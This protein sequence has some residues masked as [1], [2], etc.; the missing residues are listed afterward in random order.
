MM[1]TQNPE[2]NIASAKVLADTAKNSLDALATWD[3]N[4]D[5]IYEETMKA[6]GDVQKVVRESGF[7]AAAWPADKLLKKDVLAFLQA[8]KEHFDNL[9]KSRK[10]V[11]CRFSLYPQTQHSEN[12]TY[13]LGG[14]TKDKIPD[15]TSLS[16]LLQSALIAHMVIFERANGSVRGTIFQ[17]EKIGNLSP[18]Q[19]RSR[20]R[21]IE[22]MLAGIVDNLNIV[23]RHSVNNF[24]AAVATMVRHLPATTQAL[25]SGEMIKSVLKQAGG[26]YSQLSAEWIEKAF[27]FFA[28][29]AILVSSPAS[30]QDAILARATTALFLD[31]VAWVNEQLMG[32]NPRALELALHTIHS[33]P[34]SFRVCTS[35]KSL[36]E[37]LHALSE[38][39][40][41]FSDE[42]VL[43]A[44]LENTYKVTFSASLS[45]VTDALLCTLLAARNS[46]GYFAGFLKGEHQLLSTSYDAD[47]LRNRLDPR[48]LE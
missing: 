22:G 19:K 33:R 46:V 23:G 24:R 4:S 9:R 35:E 13:Q 32:L 2:P 26:K 25:V 43:R 27:P 15:K 18:E 5:K 21:Y 38:N 39:A 14:R 31:D 28:R 45:D 40:I 34:S 29:V 1:T 17:N 10:P 3:E 11:L 16:L 8:A 6:I 47:S 37:R 20:D 48:V 7:T 44:E 42:R 30:L 36:K 41:R 12:E